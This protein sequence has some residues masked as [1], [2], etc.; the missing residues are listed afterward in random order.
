MPYSHGAEKPGRDRRGLRT[1]LSETGLSVLRPGEHMGGT[2]EHFSREGK[3]L[4]GN[5]DPTL[6]AHTNL[7]ELQL[8]CASKPWTLK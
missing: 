6:A 3:R 5:L 2:P 1:K 7:N 4:A 8:P